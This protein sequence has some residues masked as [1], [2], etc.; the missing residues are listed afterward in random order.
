MIL[1][2]NQ[3]PENVTPHFKGGEKEMA[4]IQ[5]CRIPLALR[6]ERMIKAYIDMVYLQPGY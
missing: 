2:F 6:A 3:I 4:I 1:D 5:H